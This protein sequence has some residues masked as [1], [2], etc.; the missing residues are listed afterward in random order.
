[1]EKVSLVPSSSHVLPLLKEKKICRALQFVTR[2]Y[3]YISKS[4][5]TW[6]LAYSNGLISEKF[7]YICHTLRNDCWH[8]F[9]RGYQ[10]IDIA[11][12]CFQRLPSRGQDR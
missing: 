11:N 8:R 12:S 9:F 2:F 10:S 4:M 5:R 6:M 7:A 3:A 1:M